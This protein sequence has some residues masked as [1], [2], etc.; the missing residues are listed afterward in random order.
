MSVEDALKIAWVGPPT[1]ECFVGRKF[2][3]PWCIG[4]HD[5]NG[6]VVEEHDNEKHT[7]LLCNRLL[8]NAWRAV[9][10]R[11][12]CTFIAPVPNFPYALECKECQ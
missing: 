5:V 12:R 2:K 1:A 3:L 7:C 9:C 11:C 6:L 8:A 10:P 4:W